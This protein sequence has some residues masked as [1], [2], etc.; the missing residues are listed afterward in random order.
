MALIYP[1]KKDEIF[2]RVESEYLKRF[3]RLEGKYS[4]HLCRTADG[5]RL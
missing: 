2:A 1:A 3:P 5:V 4:A